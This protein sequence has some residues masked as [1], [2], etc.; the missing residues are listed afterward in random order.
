MAKSLYFGLMNPCLK[1]ISAL[2]VLFLLACPPAQSQ[3]TGYKARYTTAAP[4]ITGETQIGAADGGTFVL[5]KWSTTIEDS[6]RVMVMKL[7]PY[8]NVQWCKYINTG[9]Q[10]ENFNIYECSDGSI[11]IAVDLHYYINLVNFADIL[12]IKLNCRG[13]VLWNRR[14]NMPAIGQKWLAPNSIKEGKSGDLLLTIYNSGV[15]QFCVVAR[16]DDS[17]NLVWS[18]TFNAPAMAPGFQS[19][20]Y[21]PIAFLQDNTVLVFGFKDEFNNSYDYNKQIFALQLNY[22]NGATILS[23][24]YTYSEFPTNYGLFGTSPKNYFNAVHLT[25]G[26][27]A[28]FGIFSNFNLQNGYVY[29]LIINKDLSI[30]T[31]RAFVVPYG[32]AI[33]YGNISVLPNGQTH[34]TSQD[35]DNYNV[36]WYAGDNTFNTIRSVKIP[37]PN[38][39]IFGGNMVS[40]SGTTRSDYMQD[41]YDMAISKR[42]IEETQVEDGNNKILPCLGSDF[43][44][45][46]TTPL[47][48][49]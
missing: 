19:T 3:N 44:F 14:L 49:N 26:T 40:Q 11:A 9:G 36:C 13:E 42:Y 6:S 4:V 28:L 31:A 29:R 24:A 20:L 43:S 33:P 21:T 37:Y 45:I 41:G 34:I 2:S 12:L 48:V 17:G 35:Y 25:D 22:D 27:Y 7:D 5:G 15:D 32:Q 39:S 18:K 8:G 10:V 1:A 23:K 46:T 30:N 38:N 47:Q 16:I